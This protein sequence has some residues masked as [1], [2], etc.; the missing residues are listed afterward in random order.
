MT[1]LYKLISK[2]PGSSL[3][4]TRCTLSNITSKSNNKYTLLAPIEMV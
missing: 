4:T 2:G 3:A 1:Y